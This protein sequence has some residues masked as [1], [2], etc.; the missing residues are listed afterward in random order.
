MPEVG[1]IRQDRRRPSLRPGKNH[2]KMSR[3]PTKTNGF[4]RFCSFW[5]QKSSKMSRMPTKTNVFLIFCSFWGDFCPPAGRISASDL[6]IDLLAGRILDPRFLEL[7]LGFPPGGFFL[8]RQK[9]TVHL[10]EGSCDPQAILF[11]PQSTSSPGSS[12]KLL[13]GE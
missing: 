4:L 12:K 3:M 11:F 7:I 6:V 8:S 2:H 9:N 5:G 1:R 13:T 10:D